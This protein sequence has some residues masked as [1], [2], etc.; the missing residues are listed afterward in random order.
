MD[1]DSNRMAVTKKV[2]SGRMFV[3][4][5]LLVFFSRKEALLGK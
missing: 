2:E 1:V 5:L 3:T 4:S